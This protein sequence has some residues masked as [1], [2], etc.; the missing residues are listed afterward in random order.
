MERFLQDMRYAARSLSR[1][2]RFTATVV[3]VLALG[4]AANTAMFSVVSAVL[5]KPFRYPDP[6]RIVIFTSSTSQGS[7]SIASPTKF[8]VWRQQTEA[9]EDVSAY[10]FGS[11]NLT[12]IDIPL[13]VT[14]AQVSESF[15][16]LFGVTI[17]RGRS[18]TLDEDRPGGRRVTV[19]SE[20][21]WRRHFGGDPRV[22][23]KAI[24][25]NGSPYEVVGVASAVETTSP[26]QIDVWMPFQI[27]PNSTS[28]ANALRAVGRLK[29]RM[30]LSQANAQLQLA[31][32]EF[33]RRFP[34]A[35]SPGASFM[36]QPYVDSVARD[37]RSS[38]FV[39]LGAVTFVLLMACSNVA[40]L[41]LV[42]ATG[43]GREIAVRAALGASR[44]RII[45]QLLTESVVL[46][47]A[48]G[49]L[50]LLL[51]IGGIHALL[52]S[53]PG[54]IPRIGEHGDVSLD[55]R[56]LAYT[57]L[58][59]LIT[60]VVFGIIPAFRASRGSLS[61]A[62]NESAGRAVGGFRQNR[63]SSLLVVTE[64]SLALMLL[65]GAALLIR[66]FV[67]LRSVRTGFDQHNVLTVR[68]S[69]SGAGF[70]KTSAVAELAADGVQRIRALPG[71]VAA[72]VSCCLPLEGDLGMPFIV[73][74]RH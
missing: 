65:V 7:A 69:L 20:S 43:R 56:V 64:I 60:G 2:P 25:L 49:A 31:V 40:N 19:L 12:G 24:S 71:V 74:G 63:V 32:G 13:Q 16:R 52:R 10:M 33:R 48:G 21:L 55:W 11:A 51:G 18:F 66:T 45:R 70:A 30:T 57:A 53:N 29:P 67:S 68:M 41:L 35:M 28:H 50:G 14:S 6:D 5:L 61:I 42:R 54:T 73:E 72:A 8:N 58:M 44:S 38:L 37:V 15:F 23:G 47:L 17:I 3:A 4:I 36:A 34:A 26:Q 22:V 39:L 9:F 1:T 27:D 46:S 59:T 62:L